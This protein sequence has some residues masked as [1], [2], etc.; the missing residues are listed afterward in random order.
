MM[1]Q[2]VDL[3]ETY[4]VRIVGYADILGWAK[5]SKEAS[6]FEKLKDAVASIALH[7]SNFEKSIKNVLNQTE[8]IS[9]ESKQ[10]HAGIEFS[11][12]SDNF[13][14]SAPATKENA[15]M[16]FRVLG[17]ASHELLIREFSVR[18]AVTIGNLYH[19]DH[20]IF[21]QALVEA[22]AIEQKKSIYPRLLCSDALINF[23]ML[24]VNKVDGL[25]RDQMENWIVN[26][27][28]GASQLVQHEL[29]K[30]IESQ[31]EKADCD[32]HKKKWRYLQEVLPIMYS[33]KS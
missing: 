12:F 27:A 24:S 26:C 14:V 25:L 29:N 31:I 30:V 9:V 22:V 1:W 20:I 19:A 5:K 8:G 18:G 21:G 15:E 23:L 32:K 10:K 2:K 16:I 11:F 7:A 13:A 4:E 17:W 6:S 28:F 33:A 3:S